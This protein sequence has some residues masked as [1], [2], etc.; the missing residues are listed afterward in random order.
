M[1][2]ALSSH[3]VCAIALVSLLDLAV[4]CSERGPGGA[5]TVPTLTGQLVACIADLRSAT[6]R[7]DAPSGPSA[8]R[9]TPGFSGYLI[10]G[11]QA[12]YVELSWANAGNK[13]ATRRC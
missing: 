5:G 6:L 3:R 9:G 13:G 4:A 11:A 2:R 8:G 7:C 12:I 10:V 1:P